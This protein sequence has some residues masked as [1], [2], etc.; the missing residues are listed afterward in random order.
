MLKR[1]LSKYPIRF[2]ELLEWRSRLDLHQVLLPG[3]P[4]IMSSSGFTRLSGKCVVNAKPSGAKEIAIR[5]LN[6]HRSLEKAAPPKKTR[7][8]AQKKRPTVS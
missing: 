7:A 6:D 4:Q 8:A 3:R 5:H 2:L 1:K